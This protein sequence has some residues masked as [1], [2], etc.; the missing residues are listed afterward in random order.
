MIID[1]GKLPYN[2]L[3]NII[4][5]FSFSDN[6]M[7]KGPGIGLDCA[8]F[9]N[10]SDFIVVTSDP[11]TY[12][13]S[14]EYCVNVNVNDIAAMG[15]EPWFFLCTIILPVG[16]EEKIFEGIMDEIKKECERFKINFGGGHTEINKIVKSPVICG[17]MVGKCKKEE[18]R[19]SFNAKDGDILIVTKGISVEGTS[20]I[21]ESKSKEIIEQ[22]GVEFYKKCISYRSKL[23]VL[24]EARIARAMSNAM[25]DITEGGLINGLYEIAEASDVSIDID[26]FPIIP[27]CKILCDSLGINPLG[28]ITAGTLA[29]T[30]DKRDLKDVLKNNGIEVFEIGKIVKDGKKE[31]RYKGVVQEIFNKDEIV[32]FFQGDDNLEVNS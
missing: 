4:R 22:Y 27:E 16:F 2:I 21:A 6:T 10:G 14:G 1:E 5:R 17:F 13:A 3:E 9:D 24:S 31:V 26:C 18:L 8:V 32:K 25:H 15:G 20:I 11:V 12:V 29:I 19:G 28:L 30:T 23:S 7:I